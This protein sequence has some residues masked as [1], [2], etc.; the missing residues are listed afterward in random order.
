MK[1]TTKNLL[2]CKKEKEEQVRKNFAKAID[3]NDL[4][5]ES[6]DRNKITEDNINEMMREIRLS[7]L[8]ADVNYKVVKENL[9]T[10]LLI[11]SG[12]VCAIYNGKEYI[13]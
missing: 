9:N 4:V 10:W 1:Q 5:L 3:N 12:Y 2:F 13:K 8:E 7:L 6:L 11:P